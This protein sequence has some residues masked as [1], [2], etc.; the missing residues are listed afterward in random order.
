MARCGEAM[1]EVMRAHRID[2]QPGRQA[3]LVGVRY[4]RQRSDHS[5]LDRR[6][7]GA[8]GNLC[9][10]AEADLMEAPRQMGGDPVTLW[11][12]AIGRLSHNLTI[13]SRHN[14]G[15]NS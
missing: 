14:W 6:Q 8:L 7:I 3:A 9:R 5:V 2:A 15:V 13:V 4:F 12:A 1:D 10:D 11:N